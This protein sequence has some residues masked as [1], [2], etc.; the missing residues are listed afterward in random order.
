MIH[1]TIKALQLELTHIADFTRIP[2]RH[3][4]TI[5]NAKHPG[6]VS[7]SASYIKEA[8]SLNLFRKKT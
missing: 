1:S 8:Q 5:F 7:E 3:M 2:L 6:K 4:S